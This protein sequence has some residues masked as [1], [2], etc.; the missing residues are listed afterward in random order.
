M[1]TTPQ[2]PDAVKTRLLQLA[3]YVATKPLASMS[4]AATIFAALDAAYAAGY[5]DGMVKQP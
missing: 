2:M 3:E 1:T 4:L 5:K